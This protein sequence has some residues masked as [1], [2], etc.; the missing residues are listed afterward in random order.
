MVHVHPVDDREVEIVLDHRLRDMCGK[1]RMT[2]D[3]RHRSGAPAFVG[4]LELGRAADRERGNHVQAEGRRMIVVDEKDDVRP[5]A[6]SIHALEN[7]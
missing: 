4:R 7:S 2:M 5:V 6:P 3:D 1:L